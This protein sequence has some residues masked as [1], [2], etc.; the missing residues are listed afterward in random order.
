M[1]KRK[2]CI[3]LAISLAMLFLMADFYT[4]PTRADTLIDNITVTSGTGV[5]IVK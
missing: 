5:F 1:K 2:L 4:L 3:I